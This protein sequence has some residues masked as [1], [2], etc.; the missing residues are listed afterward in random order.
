MSNASVLP[1][2]RRLQSEET[3]ETPR[4]PQS[5]SLGLTP[6][7][8]TIPICFQASVQSLCSTNLLPNNDCGPF[9]FCVGFSLIH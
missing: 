1:S 3:P 8:S 7:S 5:L 4:F 2:H 9:I 6:A